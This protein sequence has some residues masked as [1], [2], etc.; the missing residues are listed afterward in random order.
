MQNLDII[1]SMLQ[2]SMGLSA[3]E[4]I[5]SAA[6]ITAVKQ[7][8]AVLALDGESEYLHLLRESSIEFNALV[9]RVALS[10]S[11]SWFFRNP[12]LFQALRHF[13]LDEWLPNNATEVLRVLSLPCST[14]EEPYTIAML[15]VELGIPKERLHIDAVDISE[16]HLVVARQAVYGNNSFRGDDLSYRDR[17]FTH[18]SGRYVLTDKIK[19]MVN[20]TQGNLLEPDFASSREPYDVVLCRNLMVYFDAPT[21]EKAVNAVNQLVTRKGV[22]WCQGKKRPHGVYS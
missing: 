15:L 4:S 10:I 16:Q 18:M 5:G 17:Y 3:A 14:G 21:R 19:S 13:L 8:M 12:K 11:E 22:L 1:E 20:F 7:R 6:I 2:D 9:E